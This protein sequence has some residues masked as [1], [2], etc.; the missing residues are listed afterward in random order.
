MSRLDSREATGRESKDAWEVGSRSLHVMS[1]K[2]DMHFF[3][4]AGGSDCGQ[5]CLIF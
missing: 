5:L 4:G 2:N 3:P 1:Q